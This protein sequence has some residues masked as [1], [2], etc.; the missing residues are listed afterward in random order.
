MY[1][2][3]EIFSHLGKHHM[4]NN[5]FLDAGHLIISEV[6]GMTR[7][8]VNA[9][10]DLAGISQDLTVRSGEQS[11]PRCS[12][13]RRKGIKHLSGMISHSEKIMNSNT[14]LAQLLSSTG[15]ELKTSVEGLEKLVR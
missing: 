15:H 5:E 4:F 7:S 3:I 8:I 14:E 1:C 2:F 10:Q 6:T 11:P 12:I 9:S 13:R